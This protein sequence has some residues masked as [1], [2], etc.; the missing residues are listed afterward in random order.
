[1]DIEKLKNAYYSKTNSEAAR[2][3]NCSVPT[4]LKKIDK[5]GIERKGSGRPYGNKDG[6][7]Y[8]STDIWDEMNVLD[9]PN[10]KY[11]F[12]YLI[13]NSV[14]SQNNWKGYTG[15]EVGGF[16]NSEEDIS[17][18][19]NSL[20]SK[21]FIKWVECKN[22]RFYSEVVKREKYV[23]TEKEYIMLEV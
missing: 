8:I 11:L 19:F 23:L 12:L 1:M 17:S 13:S 3:M 10:E 16:N 9:N 14:F 2:E 21:G 20:L 5:A 7:V 6:Q 15:V 18:N 22:G 4:L